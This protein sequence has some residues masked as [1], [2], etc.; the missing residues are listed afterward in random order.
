M[1]V[2]ASCST[3]LHEPVPAGSAQRQRR[4]GLAIGAS[5][6]P[7]PVRKVPDAVHG[8]G[9]A[10]RGARTGG[11]VRFRRESRP[12]PRGSTADQSTRTPGERPSRR[13]NARQAD[14]DR[15]DVQYR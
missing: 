10:V 2:A 7:V 15:T 5:F 3:R 1:R 4:G 9:R 12:G 11:V 14:A 8:H 6:G 13:G